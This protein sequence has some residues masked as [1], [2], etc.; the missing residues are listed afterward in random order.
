MK[1]FVKSKE[2]A[3]PIVVDTNVL[4]PSLYMATPLLRFVLS[5]NLILFQTPT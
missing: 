2:I 3:V 5:G 4:I 1:S